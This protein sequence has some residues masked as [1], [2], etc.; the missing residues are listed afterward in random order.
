[1][2]KPFRA[3]VTGSYP[4]PVQPSDTLKKPTLSRQ[5]ADEIIRWA[6]RGQVDAGLDVITDGEG[7]RENMYYFFQ[8]RLDGLSFEEMVY[9]TYGTAGFGI[10]IASVVDKIGNPRF[11]LARDWRT[12]REVVPSQVEVKMT[13]AGPHLLA[14]FS[15]NKRPDLYP[16]DKDLALAYAEVLNRELKDVVRAGCEF[17]QFDEPAWTAFPEEVMWASEVLNRTIEGLNVKIGLHVC[18]GN[19]RR[20]RVY[21]TR[22]DDLAEG[23]RLVKID[24]ASLEYC[25][26][27]YNMLTLWEQWKFKG[28]FAVG[29]V[30][31]RSN[32]IESPEAVAERTRPVLD[33][34]DPERVLLTSECGFQHVPL[35]I[36]RGKLRALVAGA[37]YLRERMV[38]QA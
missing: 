21:F 20:K 31:Q 19:P 38:P 16:T 18:G 10:E 9:R 25:T 32:E 12:A 3:S 33:Y 36:T 37:R 35:E 5:E 22:Y 13:C 30:D 4:R 29:V 15:N 2:P 27:G 17:I 1:M 26:L 6:A 14:K 28:E 7:R 34:F 11:E 23:F 24:Q 8:K